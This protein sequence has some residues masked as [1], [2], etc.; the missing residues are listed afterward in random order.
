MDS[1]IICG[2]T[3]ATQEYYLEELEET[4][5]RLGKEL[6]EDCSIFKPLQEK[7]VEAY[8]LLR[9]RHC[10]D[11]LWKAE[12]L[13]KQP[14]SERPHLFVMSEVFLRKVA[15]EVGFDR[16]G[17]GEEGVFISGVELGNVSV[18][19]DIAAFDKKTTSVSIS[20]PPEEVRHV[21]EMFARYGTRPHAVFHSHPGNGPQ[22][23][24]ST[25]LNNHD[26]WEK[27]WPI[28]G[29]VFTNDGYVTCYTKNLNFMV[30]VQGKNVQQVEKN[31]W[32]L[33]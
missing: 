4:L 31:T 28:L 7:H 23:P 10:V 32:R 18:L 14:P 12:N 16:N 21:V 33:L 27:F 8:K 13:I 2:G 25:D 1:V 24:S 20:A 26:V 3:K 5:G 11:L 30:K 6:I 15:Q 9:L 17:R 19:T 22:G 29:G